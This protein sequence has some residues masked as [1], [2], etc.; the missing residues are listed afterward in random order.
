MLC[1]NKNVTLIEV[2][3]TQ[4]QVVRFRIV[5]TGVKQQKWAEILYII[6]QVSFTHLHDKISWRWKNRGKFSIKS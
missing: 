6:S 4:G 5:L 2:I 1:V 3:Q